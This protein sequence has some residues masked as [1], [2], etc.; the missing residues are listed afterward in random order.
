MNTPDLDVLAKGTSEPVLVLSS[1]G[2]ILA[3]NE[4]AGRFLG[5]KKN[6]NTLGSLINRS[7]FDI[8]IRSIPAQEVVSPD[9]SSLLKLAAS[10]I[11]H[12][13]AGDSRISGLSEFDLYRLEQDITNSFWDEEDEL[14]AAQEID[15]LVSRRAEAS[16]PYQDESKRPLPPIMARMCVRAF[17]S[18]ESLFFTLTFYRPGARQPVDQSP[19]EAGQQRRSSSAFI[20]LPGPVMQSNKE[21][22]SLDN[23]ALHCAG[24]LELDGYALY[25]TQSWYDMTGLT[26]KESLGHGWTA[27]IHPDDI[28]ALLYTFRGNIV[29][30]DEAMTYEARY[31]MRDASYRYFLVRAH[32]LKD[33]AGNRTKWYYAMMDMN[34]YV[35]ERHE[36]ERHRKS[37]MNL[38]SQ[39][40]VSL[41]G[42]NRA[43]ETYIHEGALSW[44]PPHVGK[45]AVSTQFIDGFSDDPEKRSEI[46]SIIQKV[47]E[48]RLPIQT[49]EHQVND[50]WYRTTFMAELD[51]CLTSNIDKPSVRAV[52]GLTMDVTDARARTTLQVECGR[53]IANERAAKES[54]KLKS[55]FLANVST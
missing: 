41:W 16:E 20:D 45:R 43:Y 25:L 15:V 18:K 17:T 6:R 31:R 27:A 13:S 39:A 2:L 42:I 47:M 21:D 9:L 49:L 35:V 44:S 53:L 24:Y 29:N 19:Y 37:V 32:A 50:R 5:L 46:Q 38:L 3:A 34:D 8:G 54:T 48:G 30:N 4:G 33:E 11:F 1:S 52:L 55:Q 36:T 22:T 40:D 28:D 23:I 10:R 14:T 12:P 26:E 51:P 7:V